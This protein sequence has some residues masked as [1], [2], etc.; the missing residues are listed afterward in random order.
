M[1]CGFVMATVSEPGL[2]THLGF[3][4]LAFLWFFTGLEAYRTVRR[5]NT[6]AH[7]QWMIRNFALTLAAVTLRNYMPLM[8]FAFGWCFRQSYITVSSL[9]W[10]PNLLVA[11]WLARR[12]QRQ[13]HSVS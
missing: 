4:M 13:A 3:G 8:L 9:C 6:F 1:H 11:E 10:V 2:P 5:G 7:R 12:P